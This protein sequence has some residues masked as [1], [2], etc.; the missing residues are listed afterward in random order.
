[1]ADIKKK[2][3]NNTNIK[4]LD[5]TKIYSQR[6]KNKIINA[7]EKGFMQDDTNNSNEEDNSPTEYGINKIIDNSKK[8]SN[9]S[10]NK[11]VEYHE[12]SII[13][14]KKNIE[15]AKNKVNNIKIKKK[16]Y[17]RN[18]KEKSRN[19][20]DIIESIEDYNNTQ[21]DLKSEFQNLKQIRNTNVIKTKRKFNNFSKNTLEIPQMKLNKSNIMQKEAEKV[22]KKS[23]HISKVTA[24]NI[25][26][27]AKKGIRTMILA[28]KAIIKSTQALLYGIIALGSVSI[29]LIV[30]VCFIALICSSA[31]G[32]FFSN[33][34]TGKG[35]TMNSVVTEINTEFTQK[36]A[37]IQLTVPHDEFEIH[38]NRAEWKDMLTI[39]SV[40]V[41][42]GNDQSNVMILDDK[43]VQT[44]KKVFWAMND[45]HYRTQ[46]VIRE[47]QIINDNGSVT[48]KKVIRK[49]LYIDITSKSVDQMIEEYHFNKKQKTQLAEI[50]K[51]KYNG[52]W[53]NVLYG[54]SAGSTDIVN[55][56][57]SQIGNSGGET[58]WRW[59]GFNA[60]VEWCAC[61][62]SWC[63]NECGYIDA[64][65]IP[66][67]A[68]CHN[69]GIAWFQ[70]CG[71]WQERGYTPKSRRY[72]LF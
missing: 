15:I 58:F 34:M 66:K 8:V 71:L 36:I 31:M 22:F 21:N 1:M 7:K 64:G 59:Y 63:A 62:V 9:K 46:N 10:T 41:T 51:E 42:G 43:N 68:A 55:V 17:D 67:F 24:E 54:T 20:K 3:K 60:R 27:K 11:V 12:K 48:T 28:I 53:S 50:R 35:R 4:K 65:I 25:K 2:E 5:K 32:I 52:L 18:I 44:L 23:I 57:L 45:I 38:S 13:E 40:V 26:K 47:I 37:E 49:V 70:A 19:S 16:L 29:L 30:I 56:A 72:N 39:Y 14:T 69:E 61:F 33:E 6:M